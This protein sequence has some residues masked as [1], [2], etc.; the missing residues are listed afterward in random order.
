VAA[1]PS[2][3]WPSAAAPSVTVAVLEDGVRDVMLSKMV[4]VK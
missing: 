2:T 4:S 3:V 1:A